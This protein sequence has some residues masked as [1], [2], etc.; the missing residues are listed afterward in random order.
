MG[1]DF[2]IHRK[3]PGQSEDRMIVSGSKVEMLRQFANL[4]ESTRSQYFMMQGGVEWNHL[5]VD[6]MLRDEMAQKPTGGDY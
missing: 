1:G 3:R 4:P 2:S 6:N 5:E